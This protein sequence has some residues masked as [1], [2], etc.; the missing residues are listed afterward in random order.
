MSE[1]WPFGTHQPVKQATGSARTDL[2]LS[3][4]EQMTKNMIDNK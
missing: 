3:L 4:G 2:T 1:L